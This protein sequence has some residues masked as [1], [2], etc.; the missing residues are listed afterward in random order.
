MKREGILL[1]FVVVTALPLC[2]AVAAHPGHGT[3]IVEPSDPGTVS[4][5]TSTGTGSSSGSSQSSSSSGSTSKPANS[6]EAGQSGQGGTT[7][8]QTGSTD[9]TAGEEVGSTEA[10][11]TTGQSGSQ[12]TQEPAVILLDHQATLQ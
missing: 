2:G 4:P 8:G 11:D 5:G 3:P 1:I 7:V 6:T 9:N 12:V 10:A